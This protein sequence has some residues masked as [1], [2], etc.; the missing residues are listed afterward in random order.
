[1]KFPK[2]KYPRLCRLTPYVV[3]IGIGAL[4]IVLG[5]ALPIPEELQALILIGSLVGLLVFLL[6][7]FMALMM[8]DVYLAALCCLCT[9]RKRYRLPRRRTADA[10]RRSILRFGRACQP[11]CVV[12]EPTALRYRFSQPMSIY[13]RGIE[14]VIAAYEADML[15][16][17]TY[18]NIL[19]SAEINSR[20]LIGKKKA[21]FLDRQQ[22]TAP[23]HR[24]TVVP[25][26]ARQ[27]DPA[28]DLYS[29]VCKNCGD[30]ESSCT[31]PCVVNLSDQ[32]CVFNCQRLPYVGF[33]YPVKNRGIRLIRKR[34]FGGNLNLKE[35][36]GLLDSD[37]DFGPED[38]LWDVWKLIFQEIIGSKKKLRQRFETLPARK[39][40][41]EGES[42]LLKWDDR[43]V[44]Q[45]TET[46]EDR[47]VVQ[48]EALSKWAYPKTQPISKEQTR[49]IEEAIR[50]Y[51]A[52]KGCTVEFVDD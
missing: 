4:P 7:N 18:R 20:S 44:C 25:I 24:V 17:E 26:L 28:L 47:R 12:P 42:L 5:Y 48:V 31:L 19:R 29:L 33:G 46:D 51:F 10:I 32:S 41:V 23:L 13:S 2:L 37:Q 27:V 49:A 22:K 39:V 14:R 40:V 35:G 36:E 38:T 6:K 34:I 8:L 1:M 45:W 30:E 3:V 21:W 15:T 9:A 11:A 43:C 50:T 16:R 52:G